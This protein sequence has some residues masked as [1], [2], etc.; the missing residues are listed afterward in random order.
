VPVTTISKSPPGVRLVVETLSVAAGLVGVTVVVL[1]L[2]AT[3][4][5]DPR[6]VTAR[7]T[8]PV[9]PLTALNVIVVVAVAPWVV[10]NVVGDAPS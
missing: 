4:A 5:G 3:P 8:V 6:T 7:S 2:A 10:F 1:R 9:K